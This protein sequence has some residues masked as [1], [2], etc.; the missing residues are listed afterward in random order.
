MLFAL[1]ND[2]Y[3]FYKLITILVLIIIM[4]SSFQYDSALYMRKHIERDINEYKEDSSVFYF[5]TQSFMSYF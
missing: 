3:T 2:Y 5:R 4:D 1:E